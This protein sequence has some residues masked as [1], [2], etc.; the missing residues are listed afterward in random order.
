[1]IREKLSL[2]YTQ[3]TKQRDWLAYSLQECQVIGI[4]PTYTIDEFGRFETL[5]SRYARGVDFLIRKVFRTIDAYEFENQGTLIDTVNNAEKRGLISDVET[6]RTMKDIRN[7]LVHEYIEEALSEVFDEV[8]EYTEI[9]LEIMD[10]TLAY[11]DR[12][13]QK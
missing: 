2:E 7:T 6:L 9:L 11:I 13:L 1:M 12:T 4:R 8:L 3:L 5:C 10:A